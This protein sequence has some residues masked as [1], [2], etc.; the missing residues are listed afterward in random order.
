MV[1]CRTVSDGATKTLVT[2]YTKLIKVL[3]SKLDFQ[4]RFL[5]SKINSK[6]EH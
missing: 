6:H 2:V 1:S 5:T 3:C 4:S